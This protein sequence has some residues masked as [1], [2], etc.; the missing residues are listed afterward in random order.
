MRSNRWS[1]LGRCLLVGAAVGISTV[2]VGCQSEKERA[3][4]QT[5]YQVKEL[6][7]ALGQAPNMID[8]TTESLQ[9]ATTG[10]NPRR[11]ADV[12]ELRG[13]IDSLQ[14]LRD[15]LGR[16]VVA[17]QA[18][19]NKFFTAWAKEANSAPVAQRAQ[20]SEEMAA[21][22]E[23]RDRALGYL[24]SADAS[25]A[26]YVQQLEKIEAS[27]V[28]DLREDNVRS[29]SSSVSIAITEGNKAKEFMLRLIEQVDASLAGSK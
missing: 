12:Q 1:V 11:V 25:Y 5:A 13:R 2:S 9:R 15:R 16:E 17:A 3:A 8:L 27:L 29:L 20:I 26:K 21:R 4:G 28:G 6:R 10:Q 23:N 19:S 22:R 7:T 18:D 24:R 14:D